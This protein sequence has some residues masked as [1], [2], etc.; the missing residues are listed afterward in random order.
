MQEPDNRK[1]M[2]KDNIL[3]S[4]SIVGQREAEAVSRVIMLVIF[5]QIGE[6]RPQEQFNI[7][8][9]RKEA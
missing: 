8:G 6:F 3:I 5:K 9:D 1:F 4:H 7:M 2:M